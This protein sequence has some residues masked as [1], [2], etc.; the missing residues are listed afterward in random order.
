MKTN[1][2]RVD[3]SNLQGEESKENKSKTRHMENKWEN[4]QKR[5]K[6][7]RY[8]ETIHTYNNTK[9]SVCPL[10]QLYI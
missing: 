8:K 1:K 10:E 7:S 6:K 2:S 5:R 9:K 3:S 4:G